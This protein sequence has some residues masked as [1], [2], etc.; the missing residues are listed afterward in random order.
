METT[1]DT[2][3]QLPPPPCAAYPHRQP[4]SRDQEVEGAERRVGHDI[5]DGPHCPQSYEE[6]ACQYRLGAAQTISHCAIALPN[7]AGK[8]SRLATLIRLMGCIRPDGRNQGLA[9]RIAL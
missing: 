9:M 5:G 2:L 6:N 1:R 3:S 4:D 7:I 8:S